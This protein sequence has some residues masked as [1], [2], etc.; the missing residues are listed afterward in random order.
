MSISFSLRIKWKERGGGRE[1]GEK[2]RGGG[3][4]EGTPAIKTPIADFMVI[5][6][7]QVKTGARSSS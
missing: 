6:C 4:G 3:G 2:Q 1:F 5:A 7:R